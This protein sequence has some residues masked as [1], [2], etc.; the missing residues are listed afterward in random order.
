ML[1]I[2]FFSHF[3]NSIG[4]RISSGVFANALSDAVKRALRRGKPCRFASFHQMFRRSVAI[5]GG[6]DDTEDIVK[7]DD[8]TA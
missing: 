1:R 2:C 5:S 4:G 6:Y 3:I 8:A 7:I